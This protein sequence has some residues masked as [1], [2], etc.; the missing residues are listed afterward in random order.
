MR[1]LARMTSSAHVQTPTWLH[2]ALLRRALT[3]DLWP[4]GHTVLKYFKRSG[5]PR[6]G[7]DWEQGDVEGPGV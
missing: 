5:I 7:W 6:I 2:R 3:M 4:Y 1:A